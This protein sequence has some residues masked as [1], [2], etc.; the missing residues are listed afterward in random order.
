MKIDDAPPYSIVLYQYRELQA[1]VVVAAQQATAPK[2][3]KLMSL[4]GILDGV[5]TIIE[6]HAISKGRGLAGMVYSEISGQGGLKVIQRLLAQSVQ[7]LA[8][9]ARSVDGG[10]SGS[11]SSG[12]GGVRKRSNRGVRGASARKDYSKIKCHECGLM[13][14]MKV[15]CPSLRNKAS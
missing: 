4:K 9:D 14:H 1:A 15:A 3:E 10:G 8:L 12:G 6:S 13:G 2:L 7:L 5:Y 11:S